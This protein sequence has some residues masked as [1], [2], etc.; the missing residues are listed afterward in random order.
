MGNA[1]QAGARVLVSRLP[2]NLAPDDV[3]DYPAD[4]LERIAAAMLE[5]GATRTPG[6]A[7]VRVTSD[8]DTPEILQTVTDDMPFIV[9]SLVGLLGAEHRTIHLLLHPQLVVRRDETGRLLEILDRE[10]DD[11]LPAGT[12]A[13][14][15]T[16]I[17]LEPD[18]LRED[19]VDHL[20]ADAERVLDDVRVAV[21][22][23]D[24]MRQRAIDLAAQLEQ[25]PPHGMPAGMVHEGADFL[26]WLADGHFVFLGYQDYDLV[27]WDGQ[28]SLQSV[29]MSGLGLLHPEHRPERATSRS[30]ALLSP[31]ARAQARERTLLVLTK[32]NSRSTVHRPAYLD[33]IGVKRFDEQGTVVGESR[34]LGLFSS[35]AYAQSVME[36]P[37]LRRSYDRLAHELAHAEGSHDAKALLRFLEGYPRDELF[38]VSPEHLRR[39]VS[40]ELHLKERRHTKVYLRADDFGRYMT[41]LVHLPRDRYTT[42]VRLRIQALLMESLAG[43]TCDY[44]TRVTDAQVAQLFF[45]VRV[46]RG[47]ALP[48]LDAD[49]L[50][51]RIIDATRGWQD[52]FATQLRARV[53]DAAV[54]PLLREFHDAFPAAYEEDFSPARGVQDALTIDALAPGEIALE[55]HRPS[56]AGPRDLSLKIL[57]DGPRL[58]LAQV[59]PILGS[60]G[61]EVQE[62]RPYEITRP[63]RDP[64]WILAFHM[65]LPP[66]D[67]PATAT[68]PERL[69]EAF[70]LVW[71]GGADVDGLNALVTS[72]GLTAR[73]VTVVRAYARYLRQ[74]G[75][76]YSQRYVEEVLVAQA[77]ITRMLVALF[78]ALFGDPNVPA[79]DPDRIRTADALRAQIAAALDDV[80]SL[81]HDRILRS[82]LALIEATLRT[83]AFTGTA[84]GIALKLDPSAV[85]DV[86][87]P[88]PRFEIWVHTPR[89][90]GV[91]LRFGPVA[92]GG[93]RWTD[94]PEDFR[95]EILGLVKAQEV[96]NAVI[97]PVGA[98]GGFFPRQLPDPSDREAW[99]AEGRAAYR[100]FVSSMLDLTDNLV[101]GA[102]VPPTGVVR[103]DGDDPY[104]VVAADK[105]TA[106]FSD[107]ANAIAEEHHFWLDDAFA[108]G[109]SHGYDHKAMGITARGAWESVKRHFRE[110]GVDTQS[111]D[112]TVAGVGDMSGD[113]FGNAMLLSPHIRLVAAFDHRHVFLD[114]DPDAARSF[115]ERQ[116]LFAL[117]RSSWADYDP[118]LISAGGGVHDRRAKSVAITAEVAAVLHLGPDV[119]ALTPD[120]L[121]SAILTAPVQLLFNGGIGTYVKATTQT[122][123]DVGDRANDRVRVDG[124]ALRC[125][126]VGE[127]GNLGLTQAGRIEA[128]R[129]GVR[130]NTDAIDNSAGVDTSDHEVNIKI[131]LDAVVRSGGLSMDERNA[132]L[133]SMT[134]EVA[135]QVLCDNYDQNVALGNARAGAPELLTVHERMIR[136]LEREG[137]LNRA[138]EGLPDDEEIHT[139]LQAG[140]GLTSP[141]L[142]VLLAYAKISLTSAL[143]GSG[144]AD[145]PYFAAMLPSYF[146]TALRERYAAAMTAHP[147]RRDIVTTMVANHLVNL[148]GI[149]FAFRA[150]EETGASAAA[151]VRAAAAAIAVFDLDAINARINAQDGLIPVAAQTALHLE[152][153]RLLD[154]ATRW[155]LQARGGTLDVQAEVAE[156]ASVVEA[157]AAEVPG[158]LLGLERERFDR[159]RMRF[160]AAGVP[161]E[162]AD[163]VAGALDV[164]SLLDIT[165]ICVETG[166]TLHEI[167]P[168][169]FTVSERFDV[170]R[171]LVRITELERG[172][173]WSALARQAL[174][175]DL[176][177]ASAG[178]TAQV[179]RSTP[180]SLPPV[181][182]LAQWEAAH[183]EGVV[184][185]RATL[186]SIADVDQADLAT[187]SVALRALRSLAGQRA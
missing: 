153:R 138:L 122:N 97:V 48:S 165:D 13:E 50:E 93:L 49:D 87:L 104:L 136:A 141:E 132:L 84:T 129:R 23:W 10:V 168:L 167:L 46:P 186:D 140:Q 142:C 180:A 80:A 88:R 52:D 173:M 6:C 148:G 27:T 171:T 182:R 4:A 1:L 118:A 185:A 163:E 78:A 26:R 75:T 69:E 178:I 130:L 159:L 74:L 144:L 85:P 96:K 34:F 83:T 15:W 44:T 51:R 73:E 94:R 14:S 19:R 158:M 40:S 29:P 110:L 11:D 172:A 143:D 160:V 9:D 131:L 65:L 41:C 89:V 63:M 149:T 170:D 59:I 28:E 124:D 7:V 174:R 161:Q 106:T 100:E 76:T 113:V 71:G 184:R 61:L 98:K 55:L 72:A 155:F 179:A 151:V 119:T 112:F 25:E 95:T 134:D 30:F 67:I 150:M 125:Q 156:F 5:V 33:Y 183:R 38:Q 8:P 70:L 35:E 115:V 82:F 107:L 120:E 133:A 105:G 175:S 57:L 176:Y 157:H 101:E 128:A 102:V 43:E 77:P 114:P 45:V 91:H 39:V 147:L 111:E 177:A 187:L 116:R 17:E 56:D 137:V 99:Q 2:R 47:Q 127:G 90:E 92:R 126:V 36:V 32:A 16:W 21:R 117:P 42:P 79:D 20:A 54:G 81:D 3:D 135:A 53:G 37:L 139:R 123:A 154:R 164:F 146:P 169:Y 181:Q 31:Q 22:D 60:L 121:I 18:P 108:S 68:L 103:R 58:S 145:E 24:A 152:A 66:S 86:P 12:C 109:G 162:L 62:E 64:A 166:E